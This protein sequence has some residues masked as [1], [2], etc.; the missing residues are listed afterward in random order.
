V[1][2]TVG[3]GRRGGDAVEHVLPDLAAL[4]R[5][6]DELRRRIG[7]DDVDGIRALVRLH[8]RLRR[9][10]DAIPDAELVRARAEM[11]A[12]VGQLEA[13]ARTVEELRRLKELVG[14]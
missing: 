9:S 11:G 5:F 3:N 12:L 6:A 7:L 8:D 10:L 14:W 13:I 2:L 1:W 4:G